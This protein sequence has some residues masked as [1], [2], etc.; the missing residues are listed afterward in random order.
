[1]NAADRTACVI[2]AYQVCAQVESVVTGLRRVLP[3]AIMI[4]VDDGSTDGTFD[5][6]ERVCDVVRRIPNNRGKGVAL[7][8]GFEAA[9]ATDCSAVLTI[10]ADGQ[11]DPAAAPRLLD[12]LGGADVVVGVR[13]RSGT[14]MPWRRRATNAMSS[15]AFRMI[16][17]VRVPDIQSGYR[18]IRTNVLRSVQ[19]TGDRYEF[20]TDF[21]IRVARAGFRIAAVPVPTIYGP[22]SSFREF[23]DG[24]RVVRTVWR[25]A[26]GGARQ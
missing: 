21:L 19:A 7:R 1:M 4:G 15:S 24:A 6:L 3:R 9:L 16:T 18:A 8:I 13:E 20:E 22:P 17:G 2:P 11:H 25:H 5:I 10:D 12:A 23:T 14:A 26:I